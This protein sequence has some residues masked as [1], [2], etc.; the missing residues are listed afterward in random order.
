MKR[1]MSLLAVVCVVSS[2]ACAGAGEEAWEPSLAPELQ[3]QEQRLSTTCPPVLYPPTP[4][5]PTAINLDTWDF[6]GTPL[7]PTTSTTRSLYLIAFESPVDE[8]RLYVYG[9]DVV[10]RRFIFT[11]TIAKS[12][13]GRLT[14]RAGIDIG[15]F[16]LTGGSRA[17]VGIEIEGPTPPPPPPAIDETDPEDYGPTAFKAAV[18]IDKVMGSLRL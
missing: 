4:W 17:G 6:A 12:F 13:V 2:L 15:Q 5:V 1:V 9:I 7:L 18:D 8:T 16:H 3:A 11:G 10:A 14:Q